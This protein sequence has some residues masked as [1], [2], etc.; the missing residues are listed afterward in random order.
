MKRADG[1]PGYMH[2]TEKDM[3]LV[4]A[5]GLPRSPPKY[6]SSRDARR[7]SIESMRLWERAIQPHLPWFRLEFVEK[8]PTAAVQVKW[9]RKITGPWGGFGGMRWGYSDG[10]LRVGGVMEVS[11]TPSNFIRLEI[12]EVRD[13][14]AHE[15]GHVLGLGHCHECDSA[16]NYAD[17]TETRD[18]VQVKPI[19]IRT[20]L[21]LVEQPNALPRLHD[22][23]ATA[24]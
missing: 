14:I 20:F 23:A 3:P 21:A 5:I 22:A 11:T 1:T 7:V 12:D 4:V 16:M 19:D 10:V 6:G 9:K 24:R 17:A 2:V 13:L 18:G 8:S 15:F